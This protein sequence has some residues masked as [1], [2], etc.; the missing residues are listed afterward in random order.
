MA[1]ATQEGMA[2]TC[3]K[4]LRAAPHFQI[5]GLAERESTR[6]IC[7]VATYLAEQQSGGGG[8]YL[9]ATNGQANPQAIAEAVM[10][11]RRTRWP[12]YIAGE[13]MGLRHFI[14]VDNGA[15][16]WELWHEGGNWYAV[17]GADR[18]GRALYKAEGQPMSQPVAGVIK[19]MGIDEVLPRFL[20]TYAGPAA[21]YKGKGGCGSCPGAGQW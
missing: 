8:G 9:A 17:T 5:P 11:L 21:V 14:S 19:G 7:K 15:N 20:R 3:E 16:Y 12:E 2:A 1:T 6:V 18:D 4:I 10:Q 13:G